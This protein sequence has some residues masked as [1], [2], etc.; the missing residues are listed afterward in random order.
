MDV[1]IIV[2]R[3]LAERG[4]KIDHQHTPRIYT[5][6]L[7]NNKTQTVEVAKSQFRTTA[8][9]GEAVLLNPEWVNEEWR[10]REIIEDNARK[11][12][13]PVPVS[14][15]VGAIVELGGVA[16]AT[17]LDKMYLVEVYRIPHEEIFCIFD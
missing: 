10:R 15:V 2:H 8:S 7:E 9:W 4:L 16:W 14:K 17:L 13:V 5:L 6:P 11:Q 3:E 12:H 1:A